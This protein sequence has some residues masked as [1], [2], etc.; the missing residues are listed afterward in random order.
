I[1]ST[2]TPV[3]AQRVLIYDSQGNQEVLTET[4]KGYYETAP[5]G[6][7][8][9]VGRTYTVRIELGDGRTYESLPDTLLPRGS[10]D[11]LYR[12]LVSTPASVNGISYAFDI[13]LDAT[14]E[15]GSS[16]FMW[17][18]AGTFK[19]DTRPDL[20]DVTKTGCNPIPTEFNK[21]NFLPL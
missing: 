11:S 16:R 14:S 1:E 7:R 3:S 8:G 13:S 4:R 15:S 17:T 21:C 20:A 9:V 12:T 6:L 10:L 18:F 5:S 19:S 2:K